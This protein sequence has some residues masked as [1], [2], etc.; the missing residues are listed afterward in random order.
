MKMPQLAHETLACMGEPAGWVSGQSQMRI[1]KTPASFNLLSDRIY[2][3]EFDIMEIMS[4]FLMNKL[5]IQRN[6]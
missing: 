6:M 1:D 5:V 3:I 2:N 4:N